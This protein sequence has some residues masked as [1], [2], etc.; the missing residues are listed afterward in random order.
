MFAKQAERN[1]LLP[2]RTGCLAVTV[3]AKMIRRDR[4]RGICKLLFLHD[5]LRRCDL[6]LLEIE[7]TNPN[8]PNPLF[9]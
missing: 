4:I 6:T 3:A 9:L 7:N 5:S 2:R 1:V 8:P